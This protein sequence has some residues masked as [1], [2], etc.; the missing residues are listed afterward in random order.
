MTWLSGLGIVGEASPSALG[1]VFHM[2]RCVLILF[3]CCI[4]VDFIR[5]QIFEFVRRVLSGT[6]L[7]KWF[8]I[9]DAELA[10]DKEK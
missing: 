4:F 9:I 6:R 2:I 7:F 5:S 8:G 1:M 10:V 3:V